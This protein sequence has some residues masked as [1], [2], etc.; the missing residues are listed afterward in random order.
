[1]EGGQPDT[2]PANDESTEG[3]SNYITLQSR[4]QHSQYKLTQTLFET[5][6]HYFTF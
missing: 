1:M 3:F 5:S 2:S 6:K 4:Q